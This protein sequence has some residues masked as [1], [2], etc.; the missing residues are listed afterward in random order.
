MKVKKQVSDNDTFIKNHLWPLKYGPQREIAHWSEVG[1]GR[2]IE[3]PRKT[4]M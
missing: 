3:K 1:G 2:D 4:K